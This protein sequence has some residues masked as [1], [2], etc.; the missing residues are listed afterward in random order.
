MANYMFCPHTKNNIP[1]FHN[2]GFII[3]INAPLIIKVWD[4][5]I[6]IFFMQAQHIIGH[7]EGFFMEIK[8][9]PNC[10]QCNEGQLREKKKVKVS[11]KNPEKW[12]IICFAHIKKN[13]VTNVII[14]CALVILCHCD[15]HKYIKSI[16]KSRYPIVFCLKPIIFCLKCI[17]FCLKPIKFSLK[18]TKFSF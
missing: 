16:K 6:F 10:P 15:L 3:A 4:I 2:Q 8:T 11:M 14:N 1:H 13:N 18:P 5:I 17:M 12:Q 9:F 7:F